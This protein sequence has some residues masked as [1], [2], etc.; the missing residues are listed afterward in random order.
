MV[1]PKSIFRKADLILHMNELLRLWAS[2]SRKYRVSINNALEL[3]GRHEKD[4]NTR[5]PAVESF[6]RSISFLIGATER[7]GR[8][9]T[10]LGSGI[11]LASR[12]SD[13]WDVKLMGSV[14]GGGLLI[15]GI[16][17][18]LD[19]RWAKREVDRIARSANLYFYP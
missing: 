14:M 1:N 15:T 7:A 3:Q 2:H 12:F 11:V 9:G 17:D 10:V 4:M 6:V 18:L 13:R 5:G 16:S 19:A 8:V